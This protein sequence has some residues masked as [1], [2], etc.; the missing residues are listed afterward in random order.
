MDAVEAHERVL[1]LL[2]RAE[3]G[4]LVPRQ[5]R[6]GS[7]QLVGQAD[8]VLRAGVLGHRGLAVVRQDRHVGQRHR[9]PVGRLLP[10]AF[11]LLVAAEFKAQVRPGICLLD[12]EQAAYRAVAEDARTRNLTAR[13]LVLPLWPGDS[14]T[15]S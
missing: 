2:E 11:A 12:R 6:V 9:P 15:Q 10:A 7:Q 8:D 14:A 1:R 4:P 3:H 5:R 13:A